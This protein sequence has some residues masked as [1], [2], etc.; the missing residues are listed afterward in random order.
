[1]LGF[2]SPVCSTYTWNLRRC[3]ILCLPSHSGPR[4]LSCLLLTS[5]F[6][7]VFDN[8]EFDCRTPSEWINMGL[9]P[10]SQVRRPVPGKALLPTNDVLGHGEQGQ[11]GRGQDPGWYHPGPAVALPWVPGLPWDLEALGG[12]GPT[13]LDSQL[14]YRPRGW[15]HK[16]QKCRDQG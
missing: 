6:F 5:A 2:L 16:G 7:Q 11:P 9:E 12:E 15:L 3:P 8:E 1:M 13:F 10:G 4:G 14:A